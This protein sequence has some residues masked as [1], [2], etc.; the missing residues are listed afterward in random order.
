MRHLAREDEMTKGEL[1]RA[2]KAARAAGRPLVDELALDRRAPDGAPAVESRETPRG[3]LARERW[4]R[5]YDALNGAPEGN[6][7]R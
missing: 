3:Y 2:R 1:R 6:W 5:Y 7:D 4:A